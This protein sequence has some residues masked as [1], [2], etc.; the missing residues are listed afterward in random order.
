M[1]EKYPEKVK[2]VFKSYPLRNHKSAIKAA[3]AAFAARNMGKF[4]EF[5]DRLFE[6]YDRLNDQ[7]I[8]EI[9]RDLGLDEK[10]FEKQMKDPAITA[11]IRED[12]KIASKAGVRGTPAIFINGRRLK[13]R[14]LNN[15]QV[16]IEKELKKTGE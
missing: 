3:I 1:L 9:V 6:N 7:K 12:I 15:F 11:R 4:W 2:I 10:E 14:T 5:H 16:V 13:G 8:R